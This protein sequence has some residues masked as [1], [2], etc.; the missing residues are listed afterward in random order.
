MLTV[1]ADV[2]RIIGTM[3][4]VASLARFSS[5]HSQLRLVFRGR[6]AQLVVK[7]KRNPL[8]S[9]S[10]VGMPASEARQAVE[11]GNNQICIADWAGLFVLD[12]GYEYD[13][14]AFWKRMYVDRCIETWDYPQIMGVAAHGSAEL[15]VACFNE[16]V[17]VL[18][19]DGHFVRKLACTRAVVRQFHD[20]VLTHDSITERAVQFH[21]QAVTSDGI[22]RCYVA[23]R[24]E[25]H[26]FDVESGAHVVSWRGTA[27]TTTSNTFGIAVSKE[28]VYVAS[29]K[30]GLLM[31][32]LDG[33]PLRGSPWK[34]CWRRDMIARSV[35]VCGEHVLVAVTEECADASLGQVLVFTLDGELISRYG[36]PLTGLTAAEG[37]RKL[38]GIDRRLNCMDWLDV[39]S[40]FE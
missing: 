3:I 11:L 34:R 21:P 12:K 15:L 29:E 7:L 25:V 38:I 23:S 5:T 18:R 9:V 32:T 1:D 39:Q 10:L 40:I 35:A 16:G 28:R 24:G 2:L 19:H 37:G 8:K 6:L 17:I 13:F 33:Q 20:G 14:D 31:T 26:V 22:S 36:Q 30:D 4:D 27:A